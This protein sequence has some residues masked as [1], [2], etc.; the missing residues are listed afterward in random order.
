MRVAELRAREDYDAT[1]V[2]ALKA[3]LAAYVGQPVNVSLGGPGQEWYLHRL[4][5]AYVTASPGPE[6][7]RFL[8][9]GF[10]VTHNLPRAPAQ[11]AAGTLAATSL[12]S[13]I[14]ATHAFSVDP[15]LPHAEALVILPGNRRFRLFDFAHQR[16][17][18]LAK[19][20]GALSAE[21]RCRA[22]V[23]PWL[24]VL[25]ADPAG[26][27]FEEPLC[28]G[29]PLSRAPLWA[30]RAALAEEALAI[31]D[32]YTAASATERPTPEVIDD[33]LSRC[34][35]GTPRPRGLA[36][37]TLV[38]PSHGDA[39]AG[40]VLVASGSPPVWIDWEF[41]ALRVV[42]F[43]RALHALRFRFPDGLAQRIR[44][45]MAGQAPSQA[46]LSK[47]RTAR[48]SALALFLLEELATVRDARRSLG[49]QGPA[50][51]EA[52]LLS[53]LHVVVDP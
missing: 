41:A 14:A 26:E 5:S 6:A 17:R 12:G 15:G 45:A 49:L 16:S 30:P 13:R 9:D 53:A 39:Q 11:W 33:L 46:A 28:P 19:V 22:G 32:R 2:R 50:P 4:F 51:S 21:L 31:L 44:A 1:L 24:P 52:E 42:G 29:V 10:R 23:G 35:P 20:P 36:G 43:D 27:W 3:G 37:R 18:V 47:D 8:R 38:G 48:R 40:N 25:S 7:R 34:G